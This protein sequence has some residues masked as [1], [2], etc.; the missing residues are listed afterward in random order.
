MAAL[1]WQFGFG[2]YRSIYNNFLVEVHGIQAD[3]LGLIESIREIPGL[4]TVV[5]VTLIAGMAPSAVAAIC[6][7]LMA[8]GLF[9]YPFAGGMSHL[10]A[11]TLVF[12][13]GF[14]LL[15]PPQNALVLHHA[16]EGEKGRWLG[17]LESVGA[18]AAL[19]AMATA[20]VF[21]AHVAFRGLFFIAGAV[22]TM[23]VVAFLLTP[24]PRRLSARQA[25]LGFRRAYLSYYV[26]TLLQGARRHFF[27]VFALYNLV[28]VHGV[29]TRTIAT[30]LA[31]AGVASVATRPYLGRLADRFGETRVLAW[32]FALVGLVFTG[33]AFIHDPRLLY[34]LFCLDSILT[35]E[36]VIVLH[37]YRVADGPA[38][39]TVLAGGST[40]GH[41]TGVIVPI[42]GGLLWAYAGPSAT[43]LCGTGV[44][45]AGLAYS[46]WLGRRQA[47]RLPQAPAAA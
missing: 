34:M 13:T 27:L 47:R 44:C 19:L 30:L 33:Y 41:I 39:A 6:C 28:S 5:L 9:L 4:A 43:F 15:F 7:L 37:A 17:R 1:A 25:G 24:G 42:G 14:H 23:G 26:M 12:S 40:V 10:I 46:V 31:V 45:L 20:A 11:I 2:L 35:F 8:V 18:A 36:L 16:G 38:V 21:A 3:Q 29:P 22:A 32:C